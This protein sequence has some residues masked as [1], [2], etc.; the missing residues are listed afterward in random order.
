MI[1][2]QMVRY[3]SEI[4]QKDFVV[5]LPD[6]SSGGE[7]FQRLDSFQCPFQPWNVSHLLPNGRVPTG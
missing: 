4:D 2:H 1:S 6:L 3:G 5:N 7:L